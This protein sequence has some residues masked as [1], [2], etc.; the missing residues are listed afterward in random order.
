MCQGDS[1]GVPCMYRI[2]LHRGRIIPYHTTPY[3]TIPYLP[4]A[5]HNVLPPPPPQGGGGWTS[6]SWEGN[7][8]QP[9]F[10]LPPPP[11]IPSFLSFC[12]SSATFSLQ[13]F[14]P[15]SLSLPCSV[16][17][18]FLSFN[19][20][21]LTYNF[22]SLSPLVLPHPIFSLLMLSYYTFFPTSFFSPLP[23][24]TSSSHPF[25]FLPFILHILP[26]NVASFLPLH[27]IILSLFLPFVLYI[28]PHSVP[29]FLLSPYNVPS[30]LR[31]SSSSY[32]FFP[33]RF[34]NLLPTPSI[35]SY[36]SFLPYFLPYNVPFLLPHLS[37]L[38]PLLLPVPFF[39]LPPLPI[40]IFSRR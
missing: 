8:S 35:P 6:V 32:T 33:A 19:H 39:L 40:F 34:H 31:F 1:L 5:Y 37:V 20:T 21:F 36:L 15:F 4:I 3:H 7:H 13:C 27:R 14:V 9:P 25:P 18:F 23:H 38:S 17:S 12:P 11:Q 10:H 28:L 22:P 16:L 2:K 26:Y 24:P 30:F 29:S